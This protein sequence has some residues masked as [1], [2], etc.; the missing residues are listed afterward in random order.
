MPHTPLRI[1]FYGSVSG[2]NLFTQLFMDGFADHIVIGRKL[3]RLEWKF[4]FH[5]L[6]F[7]RMV[8]KEKVRKLETVGGGNNDRTILRLDHPPRG[9]FF[10]HRQGHPGMGTTQ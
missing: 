6:Q 2:G 7:S 1:H 10:H 8:P 5:V 9:Q 4:R 3:Q